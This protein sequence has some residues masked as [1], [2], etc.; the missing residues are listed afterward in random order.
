MAR[1]TTEDDQYMKRPRR[2]F[3]GSFW[4]ATTIPNSTS[5]T[6]CYS[7]KSR[8]SVDF[9]LNTHIPDFTGTHAMGTNTDVADGVLTS[10][11]SSK[12]EVEGDV[13]DEEKTTKNELKVTQD[14]DDATRGGSP[15]SR[16]TRMMERRGE[17]QAMSG[18]KNNQ[19][20]PINV[21]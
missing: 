2:A 15:R 19:F 10:D 12:P 13:N 4:T 9:K 5:K 7:R 8:K 16:M 20:P 21:T 17:F 14:E 18:S 1:A 6:K 3:F 11:S